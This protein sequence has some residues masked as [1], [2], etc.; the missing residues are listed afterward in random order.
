MEEFNAMYPA[1][2]DFVNSTAAARVN[3][4]LGGHGTTASLEAELARL[5]LSVM[6]RKRL[7]DI[8]HARENLMH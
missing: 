7:L 8:F 2:E 1:T 6:G 4:Y 5:G 3:G